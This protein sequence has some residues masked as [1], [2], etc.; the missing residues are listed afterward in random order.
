[1]GFGVLIDASGAVWAGTAGGV[2]LSLD[3]GSSW[4]RFEADG[5]RRSLTGNWV[6][7]I[8]E[9]K[10]EDRS[11]IWMATWNTSEVDGEQFGVTFTSD[12]GETFGQALQ[13]QRIYDF[14]FDGSTVYAAGENG[15]FMSED[16]GVY[17][18]SVREFRDRTKH[19]SIVRPG[20]SVFCVEYL[21]PALWVGTSDGLVKSTD[22]GASW[23][24]YRTEVPLHPDEATER[25]PDVNTF[26][27]PNP[28]S[29]AADRFIRIRYELDVSA[30]VTVRVF[31]FG[32]SLVR[33][34]RGSGSPGLNEL[35]WDGVD[36]RGT[37]VAN[38]AY[39]YEVR[40]SG[41]RFRGKI[42][43]IE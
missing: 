17:W 41:S 30:D 37:R 35:T 31:D 8:E 43:V 3:G 7:S 25:V 39:F 21:A 20:S 26:A 15:L 16:G 38:G 40:A 4:R 27:Y 14:A 2:N 28:F 34:L 13:G 42:L 32:M 29:P 23:E 12:H 33:E 5:T 22:G 36:D 10:L 6:V 24:L 9:Q 1:M 19:D 11:V 18:T